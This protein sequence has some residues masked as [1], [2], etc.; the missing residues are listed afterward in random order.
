MPRANTCVSRSQADLVAPLEKD[1]QI[2]LIFLHNL[3]AAEKE[4]KNVNKKNQ[5]KSSALSPTQGRPQPTPNNCC[6]WISHSRDCIVKALPLH[7][8]ALV[9]WERELINF[10]HPCAIYHILV[11]VR[12]NTHFH[13][14]EHCFFGILHILLAAVCRWCANVDDKNKVNLRSLRWLQSEFRQLSQHCLHDL[15]TAANF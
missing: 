1:R 10:L 7:F 15:I 3:L 5:S 11:C 4:Y 9:E 2:S 12:D 8:F 13:S 6:C 14:K